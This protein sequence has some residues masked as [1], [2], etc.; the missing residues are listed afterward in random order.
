MIFMFFC[1]SKK[2]QPQKNSVLDEMD[3]IEQMSLEP[4]K[5]WKMYWM[6]K[7]QIYHGANLGQ[8]TFSARTAAGAWL[9][10][11]D[12]ILEHS[13][14]RRRVGSGK[15]AQYIEE[16][17]DLYD[18]DGWEEYID[19]YPGDHTLSGYVDHI[20]ENVLENDTLWIQPED[21]PCNMVWH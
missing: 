10:A 9:Q 19:L 5:G 8:V 2:M 4:V 7:N 11:R 6:E 3:E 13:N 1:S 18:D 17:A 14:M 15:N 21:E 20:I 16:P 12:Y